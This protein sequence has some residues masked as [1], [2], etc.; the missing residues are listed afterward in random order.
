MNKAYSNLRHGT[1]RKGRSLILEREKTKQ[2]SV[3]GDLL[4]T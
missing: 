3:R 4:E 1:E 2:E